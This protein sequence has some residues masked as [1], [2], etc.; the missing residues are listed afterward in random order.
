MLVGIKGLLEAS[1]FSAGSTWL[2]G[3]AMHSRS[4]YSQGFFWQGKHS[5]RGT[6]RQEEG[7]PSPHAYG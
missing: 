3:V 1:S 2:R 6:A 4:L 5:G 7:S